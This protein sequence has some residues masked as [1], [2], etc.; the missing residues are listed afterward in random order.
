MATLEPSHSAWA[1]VLLKLAGAL[2]LLL[3]LAGV[4]AASIV[5]GG[6]GVAVARGAPHGAE[7]DA[8]WLAPSAPE[9]RRADQREQTPCDAGAPRAVALT[10]D[11][12]VILNL[13]GIEDLRKLPGVGP[14]RA[15]SILALRN[16]LKRFRRLNEL[17]RVRG[18]GVRALR[19]IEPHAVLDPPPESVPVADAD[20]GAGGDA[21]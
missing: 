20:A 4:G 1:P 2:A 14:R 7:P 10:A 3:T 5:S 17:L 9:Q 12:R 11:G 13:A 15:E 6:G 8:G 18:I 21:K 19:R 16:R